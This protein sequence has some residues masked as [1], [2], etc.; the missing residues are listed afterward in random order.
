ME[1][2]SEFEDLDE[3]NDLDKSFNQPNV[4]M[5]S[6]LVY[7]DVELDLEM[8]FKLIP[9]NYDYSN[10]NYKK[11]KS[12]K[13]DSTTENCILTVNYKKESRGILGK[14][15]HNNISC[16]II[17]NGKKRYVNI[18]KSGLQLAGLKDES[19]ILEIADYMLKLFNDIETVTNYIF[20]KYEDS[21]H[22]AECIIIN[23]KSVNDND[24]SIYEYINSI[25]ILYENENDYIIFLNWFFSLKDRKIYKSKPII[26]DYYVTLINYTFKL[27]YLIN[28]QSINDKINEMKDK[29]ETC[30]TPIY[31]KDMAEFAIR[32]LLPFDD[33][34]I[35]KYKLKRKN[36]NYQLTISIYQS[37]SV[38]IS[39]P[40]R[41]LNNMA[42]DYFINTIDCIKDDIILS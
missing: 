20:D 11:I 33:D 29:G 21:K 27:G 12:I 40:C 32:L 39:G 31:N 37:G 30:F 14:S 10:V 5:I 17:I 3:T 23:D 26:K 4:S 2:T 7:F 8:I 42:Y 25:K 38:V 13:T 16:Y 24:K 28:K 34:I 19:E 36:E 18:N 6:A 15:F 1:N 41:E 9:V 35:T 22:I